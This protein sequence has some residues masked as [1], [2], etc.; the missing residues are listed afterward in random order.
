MK[1]LNENFVLKYFDVVNG[2]DRVIECFD[3][4]EVYWVQN[5]YDYDVRFYYENSLCIKNRKC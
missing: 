5:T 3:N 4:P 2:K 1:P